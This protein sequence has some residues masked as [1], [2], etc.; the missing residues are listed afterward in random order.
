M[1]KKEIISAVRITALLIFFAMAF[2]GRSKLVVYFG[3][4]GIVLFFSYAV[5]TMFSRSAARSA[6]SAKLHKRAMDD[7][8]RISEV[9]GCD[10]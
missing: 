6:E 5:Y 10:E 4:V 9:L 1:S 3:F 2:L 7:L 8:H